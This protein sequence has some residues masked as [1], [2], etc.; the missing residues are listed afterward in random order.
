MTVLLH[1]EE[2]S[3]HRKTVIFFVPICEFWA[4]FGTIYLNTNN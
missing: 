2:E 4:I 1:V 3:V